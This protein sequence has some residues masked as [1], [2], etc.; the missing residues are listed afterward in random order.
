MPSRDI[1]IIL[2]SIFG[3]CFTASIADAIMCNC[4]HCDEEKMIGS[5]EKTEEETTTP[6]WRVMYKE[7]SD[8]DGNRTICAM[9]RDFNNRTFPS[10]C[11][12]L[13]YNH[14][15]RYRVEVEG[16]DAKKHVLVAYRMNYYKLRDGAC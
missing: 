16:N 3:L 13:C 14:C 4:E 12:M 9:D 8:G 6:A 1:I 5:E 10:I 15:T 11:H 2:L 7:D